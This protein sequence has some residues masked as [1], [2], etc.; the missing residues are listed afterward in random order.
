MSD[1]SPAVLAEINYSL[2]LI[3]ETMLRHPSPYIRT[4]SLI[5]EARVAVT[6]NK[7]SALRKCREAQESAL[8]ESM[9][10]IRFD[11]VLGERDL[12]DAPKALKLLSKYDEKLVKGRYDDALDLVDEIAKA[13]GHRKPPRFITVTPLS[14]C[15]DESSPEVIL[16][17]CNMSDSSI[18][19][20]TTVLQPSFAHL[21]CPPSRALMS[22]DSTEMRLRLDGCEAG[23]Y[24]LSYTITYSVGL[25]R[26]SKRGSI[27]IAVE[28][29]GE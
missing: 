13:S 29:A 6:G 11:E 20:E 16:S 8:A 21:V 2:R 15:V 9:V 22:G 3:H 27:S 19:L 26:A 17:V 23:T 12:I 10:A 14:Y 18:I 28:A 25:E 5:R 4:K 7:S 1:L 24:T